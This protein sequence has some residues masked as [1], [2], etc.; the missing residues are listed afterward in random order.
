MSILETTYIVTSGKSI[1]Q[2]FNKVGLLCEFA[3]ESAS[4]LQLLLFWIHEQYLSATTL[5]DH[6]DIL[7]EHL[8]TEWNIR[9][10]LCRAMH[11]GDS[12]DTCRCVFTISTPTHKLQYDSHV[13]HTC[14][15]NCIYDKFA[16]GPNIENLIIPEDTR[17]TLPTDRAHIVAI[18]HPSNNQDIASYSSPNLILD[19]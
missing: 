18:I 10:S 6:L 4:N 5:Q 12:I 2:W 7:R 13:I 1:T 15:S 9:V 14:Y 8:P 16:N 11:F 17:K 19:A 3:F